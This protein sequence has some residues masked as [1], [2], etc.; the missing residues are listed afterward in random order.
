[1]SFVVKRNGLKRKSDQTKED[2]ASLEE[3][4]VELQNK[5]MEAYEL[6][7]PFHTLA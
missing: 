3:A 5:K 7:Q 2:I 1:M 6:N 4:I